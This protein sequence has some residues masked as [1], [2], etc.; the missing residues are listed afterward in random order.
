MENKIIE[1]EN[2]EKYIV[3]SSTIYDETIFGL[4][5]NVKDENEMIIAKIDNET[6]EVI[7]DK[8][9]YNELSKIFYDT[10]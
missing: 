6:I 9:L 8:K 10:L 7:N 2:N 3:V 4:L 1:L 5:V